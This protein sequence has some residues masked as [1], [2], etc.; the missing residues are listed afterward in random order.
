MKTYISGKISNLPIDQ[1]KV[2]FN[3]AANMLIARG[4]EPVNPIDVSPFSGSK[5]WADYMTDDIK[6]LFECEAIFMLKDWKD[7]RGARIEYCIAKE[8]GLEMYFEI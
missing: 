3:N 2:K 4:F 5:T 6:A 7:S 1:V 8:L